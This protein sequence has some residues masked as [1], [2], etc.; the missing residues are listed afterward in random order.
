M[1]AFPTRTCAVAMGVPGVQDAHHIRTRGREVYVL[2]APGMTVG[3]AHEL[4]E[5]V[6]RAIMQR[7]PNVIEVLVHIEPNDGHED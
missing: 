3:E 2:V 5:R 7:F 6:E 1:R 4:S